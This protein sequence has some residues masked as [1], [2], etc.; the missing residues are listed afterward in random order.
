MML[1]NDPRLVLESILTVADAEHLIAHL[2]ETLVTEIQLS[3]CDAVI[4]NKCDVTPE[5]VIE[6]AAAR[7]KTHNS[8][9]PIFRTSQSVIPPEVVMTFSNAAYKAELDS[10]VH[11][12]KHHYDRSIEQKLTEKRAETAAAI[13]LGSSPLFPIASAPSPHA[14]LVQTFCY[15][16]C[17]KRRYWKHFKHVCRSFF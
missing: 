1:A 5:A 9:A 12:L 15:C 17:Q 2:S 14:H 10:L 4:L 7:I 11:S 16:R 8:R 3:I 6:E 13:P